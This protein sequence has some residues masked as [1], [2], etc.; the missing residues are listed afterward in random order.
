MDIGV[1]TMSVGEK[2]VLHI[3][4]ALAY[5]DAKVGPI[6]PRSDLTFEIKLISAYDDTFDQVKRQIFFVILV[7]IAIVIAAPIIQDHGHHGMTTTVKQFWMT[8]FKNVFGS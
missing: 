1:E 5:G 6:P 4:P 2:S 7:M 8:A 3:P